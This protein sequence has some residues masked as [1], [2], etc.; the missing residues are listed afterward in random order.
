[1]KKL[2]FV[3]NAPIEGPGLL[4]PVAEK[5]GFCWDIIDLEEGDPLPDAS[6]YNAV[7][8]LGGPDSAN[9]DTPKIREE[10]FFI[11]G[12]ILKEVPVLGI[13]LG[14]QLLIKVEGGKVHPYLHKEIGFNYEDGKPFTVSLTPQGKTSPLFESMES[15]FPVFQLHG[16]TVELTDDMILLGAGN[17]CPNQVV[18]IASKAYGIQCHFELTQ[19]M[20]LDWASVD[21]DLSEIDL[22]LLLDSYT[23]IVDSYNFTAEKLFSNFLLNVAG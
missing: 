17:Y 1:M 20:L 18:Q 21:P 14:M 15:E 9:D 13:C 16:E 19:K 4:L 11:E 5:C 8:I 7:V 10:L 3:K 22:Q 23:D 12:L 2:L 6:E